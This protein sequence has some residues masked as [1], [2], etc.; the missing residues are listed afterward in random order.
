MN[1]VNFPM[2]WILQRYLSWM[3]FK[4]LWYFKGYTLR[5]NI[6]RQWN[7]LYLAWLRMCW[8]LTRLR[9]QVLIS[10]QRIST[11]K[12]FMKGFPWPSSS[13]W[14]ITMSF[15][16]LLLRYLPRLNIK[17]S[18]IA[19]ILDFGP[20]VMLFSIMNIWKKLTPSVKLSSKRCLFQRRSRS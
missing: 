4:H 8:S 7:V 11:R 18:V 2:C 1:S 17:Y 5:T 3:H 15:Q 19:P 16:C 14:S 12:T 20:L 10:P 13:R 6:T 9:K